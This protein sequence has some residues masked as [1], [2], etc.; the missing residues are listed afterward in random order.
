M[1]NPDHA[2]NQNS[3]NL[4]LI[5]FIEFRFKKSIPYKFILCEIHPIIFI[6]IYPRLSKIENWTSKGMQWR[7]DPSIWAL[8]I[9]VKMNN[10]DVF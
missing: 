2:S 10:N 3:Y 4:N 6:G 7:S 9:V 8:P 5:S 1:T